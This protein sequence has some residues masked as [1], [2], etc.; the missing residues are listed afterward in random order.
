MSG[1]NLVDALKTFDRDHFYTPN[2]A[3]GLV[4]AMAKAGFDESIDVA[5]RLGVDPRKADQMV[6]GTVAT[7]SV[8]TT[9]PPRSRP[10]S[11]TSTWPS[12]RPT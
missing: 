5:V 1:K 6:R 2:E 7:S 11:S 10:G 12:P 9:S 8:P 4:K 3:F